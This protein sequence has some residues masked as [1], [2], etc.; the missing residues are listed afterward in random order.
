[1]LVFGSSPSG[2]CVAKILDIFSDGDLP[3]TGILKQAA[4]KDKATMSRNSSN[5][6]GDG[7]WD[8]ELA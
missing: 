3:I 7:K 4:P 2:V 8:A 5:K 6:E 1:M